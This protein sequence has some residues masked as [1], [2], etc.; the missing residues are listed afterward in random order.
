MKYSQDG[1]NARGGPSGPWYAFQSKD[2]VF[3]SAVPVDTRGSI[4]A[5]LQ[6]IGHLKLLHF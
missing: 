6:I 4:A 1:R 3:A 5:V 2:F